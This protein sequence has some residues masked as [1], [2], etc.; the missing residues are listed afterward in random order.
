M[1][2]KKKVK[3]KKAAK[4]LPKGLKGIKCEDCKEPAVLFDKFL[5]DNHYKKIG[6]KTFRVTKQK[7]KGWCHHHA[8]AKAYV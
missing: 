6:A 1:A 5:T 8:P 4:K 2:K 3:K 7:C